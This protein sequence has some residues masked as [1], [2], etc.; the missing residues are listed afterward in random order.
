MTNAVFA[1]P[2]AQVAMIDGGSYDFFF[3]D[4]ACLRQQQFHW[5]F[6]SPIEMFTVN[7]LSDAFEVEIADIARAMRL[8]EFV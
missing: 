4:L 8:I 6:S 1:V 7:K 3:W 5:Y 2:D